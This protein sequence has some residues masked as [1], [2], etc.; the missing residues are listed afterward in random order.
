MEYTPDATVSSVINISAWAE[1]FGW[2]VLTCTPGA[3]YVCTLP[4]DPGTYMQASAHVNLVAV[5]DSYSCY[6]GAQC[7]YALRGT[8]DIVSPTSVHTAMTANWNYQTDHCWS[9]NASWGL[10]NSCQAGQ[11]NCVPVP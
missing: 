10:P 6:A 5:G 3:T 8:L 7:A 1:G 9:C 2:Q 11:T 4:G